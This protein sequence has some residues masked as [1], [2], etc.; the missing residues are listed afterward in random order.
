MNQ[1]GRKDRLDHIE[2]LLKMAA[3]QTA[4]NAKQIAQSRQEHDRE[5]KDP[6]PDMVKQVFSMLGRR[7]GPAR[8]LALTPAKRKAIAKK[9]ARARW[10]KK[11]KT[12]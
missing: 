3:A 4:E 9:A 1:N 8:A 6:S 7:G 11:R 10:G 2:E 12:A 5:K